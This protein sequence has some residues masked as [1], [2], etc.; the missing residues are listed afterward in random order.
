MKS[1]VHVVNDFIRKPSNRHPV[2]DSDRSRHLNQGYEK[3]M[4]LMEQ[5][6]QL[7]NT[8]NDPVKLTFFG[9]S[10]TGVRFVVTSEVL[11]IAGPLK[12]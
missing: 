6:A 8:Y 12:D 7:L 10:T 11:P 5:L 9:D 2:T 3:D 4:R 1:L